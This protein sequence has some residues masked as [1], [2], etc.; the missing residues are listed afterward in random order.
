M[1]RS[2]LR[3]AVA[4][5]TAGLTLTACGSDDGGSPGG[6]NGGNGADPA[7]ATSAEVAV[8]ASDPLPPAEP[9]S[10]EPHAVRVSPAVTTATAVRRVL[11][12]TCP[13]R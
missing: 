13:P 9:P 7:T 4:V 2:T 10:S 1:R 12:R 6:G 11:R 3:T 8:A 5:V